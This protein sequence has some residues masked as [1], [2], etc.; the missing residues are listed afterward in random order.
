[1]DKSI[2]SRNAKYAV[3]M[4]WE[5]LNNANDSLDLGDMGEEAFIKGNL[6]YDAWIH[7]RNYCISLI[8]SIE[9]EQDDLENNSRMIIDFLDLDSDTFPFD[10]H[11]WDQV[12]KYTYDWCPG[13]IRDD[14][15]LFLHQFDVDDIR[16][17][18]EAVSSADFYY[19]RSYAEMFI[20]CF[21]IIGE[22]T[23]KYFYDDIP[24]DTL[25]VHD[26]IVDM[27]E[28]VEDIKYYDESEPEILST[29]IDIKLSD[30]LNDLNSLIG[31]DST[32]KELNKIINLARL[33]SQREYMGYSTNAVSNHF[34]F[35]GNP[36][37]GKTTV[38][39]LLSEIFKELGLL[40]IGELIETDRAGL[41]GRYIGE[42][43][44][45]VESVVNSALG[46]VLFID[47][48]YTLAQ[49]DPERDYGKEAVD[50]LI[51]MME[52]N[53]DNLVVVVAGYP[54]EMKK[55]LDLNPGLRSRF[56]KYVY[57]DDYNKDELTLILDKLARENDFTLSDIALK[58][59]EKEFEKICNNKPENFA[60]A[61]FVRNVFEKA[62]ESCADRLSS[63]KILTDDDLRVL[64]LKD[65]EDAFEQV[66]R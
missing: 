25:T 41:C 31:L 16:N 63:K 33:R 56:N 12:N 64:A 37:T 61:R 19:G 60:N 9:S 13:W 1:M 24:S 48:A 28:I 43:A 53:R 65:L 59:A 27:K 11:I 55:F 50:Q 40:T 15:K 10:P 35:L 39:R 34:V 54:E 17:F 23:V 8:S 52:D 45:K 22:N 5:T 20:E 44:I 4:Y 62:M 46:N 2:F 38:A 7:I 57:F 32:K 36:G 3:F 21:R 26:F 30:R 47:E 18:L 58:F 49:G 29:E 6:Y 42:T 51:K 66:A 14:Y